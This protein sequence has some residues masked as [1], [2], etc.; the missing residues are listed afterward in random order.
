MVASVVAVRVVVG[1]HVSV[2]DTLLVVESMKME[3]P[4]TAPVSGAVAELPVAAADVV[5][6]GD[7]LV[8]LDPSGG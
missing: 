4:V 7:V 1:Q 3:I 6:E 8:R 2:G 5:E